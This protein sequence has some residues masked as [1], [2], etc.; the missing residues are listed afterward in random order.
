MLFPEV[1]VNAEYVMVLQDT[2]AVLTVRGAVSRSQEWKCSKIKQFLRIGG[3]QFKRILKMFEG[4]NICV[5][6]PG[7]NFCVCLVQQRWRSVARAMHSFPTKGICV[8]LRLY[9]LRLYPLNLCLG[10]QA[11]WVLIFPR[12]ENTV[13]CI[14]YQRR[15][16]IKRTKIIAFGETLFQYLQ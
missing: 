16:Q 5:P 11:Q 10:Y 12:G 7:L 1:V 3:I 4:C 15:K 14:L 6:F 13:M 8:H 2:V 9:P